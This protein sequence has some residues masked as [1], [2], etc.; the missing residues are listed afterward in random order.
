MAFI[1]KQNGKILQLEEKILQMEERILEELGA[2]K[3]VHQ[4]EV[5]GLKSQLRY[6]K[7]Y[8]CVLFLMSFCW[9]F[10]CYRCCVVV[11]K[12]HQCFYVIILFFLFC[13]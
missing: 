4:A 5:L 3:R 11:V 9:G 6:L 13:F 1:E 2:L 7:Y 12:K 8:S 10:S